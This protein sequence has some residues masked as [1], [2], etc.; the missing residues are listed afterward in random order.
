MYKQRIFLSSFSFFIL[1]ISEIV[2]GF[3]IPIGEA[4]VYGG[5]YTANSSTPDGALLNPAGIAF[6]EKAQNGA[7]LSYSILSQDILSTKDKFELVNTGTFSGLTGNLTMGPRDY[8]YGLNLSNPT[9]LRTLQ[10]FDLNTFNADAKYFQSD[11]LL[12]V[13]SA[14]AT[15]L[16]DS[17]AIG[18]ALNI[19]YQEGIESA[20]YKIYSGNI[21]IEANEA[22]SEG[23]GGAIEMRFGL[24]KKWSRFH[25]GFSLSRHR[26]LFQYMTE[27]KSSGVADTNNGGVLV[28]TKSKKRLRNPFGEKP[29]V[30]HLGADFIWTHSLHLIGE[31][32]WTSQYDSGEHAPGSYDSILNGVACVSWDLTNTYSVKVAG[33]SEL[34]SESKLNEDGVVEGTETRGVF[35]SLFVSYRTPMN[36]NFTLGGRLSRQRNSSDGTTGRLLTIAASFFSDF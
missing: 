25:L 2:L 14:L 1:C 7:S 23:K 16:S 4:L 11:L 12:S 31:L 24:L 8:V 19:E 20:E 3:Q 36:H 26:P 13:G 33:G 6:A 27:N 28:D 32:I 22:T 34:Q 21:L 18:F 17:F 35:G 5:A 29:M 10:E 15:K 9:N 30:A